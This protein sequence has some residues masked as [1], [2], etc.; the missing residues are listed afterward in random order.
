MNSEL[1]QMLREPLL[2]VP[3]GFAARILE[4]LPAEPAPCW[5]APPK[6]PKPLPM[7]QLILRWLALGATFVV[8]AA[9]LATFMLGLWLSA[10]AA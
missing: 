4:R 10:S 9:Q 3:D 8:G 5:P 7:W 6:R 2:H 1:D